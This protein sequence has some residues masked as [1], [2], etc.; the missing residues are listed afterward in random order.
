MRSG[1]ENGTLTDAETLLE[2]LPMW[3]VIYEL[4]LESRGHYV[5]EPVYIED[6]GMAKE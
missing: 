2:F 3:R 1:Y 6:P 4:V 5:E